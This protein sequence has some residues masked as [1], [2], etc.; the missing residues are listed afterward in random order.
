MRNVISVLTLQQTAKGAYYSTVY[1]TV[2]LCMENAKDIR[3]IFTYVCMYV[4][5]AGASRWTVC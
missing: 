1:A 5:T 3:T 2:E 4:S